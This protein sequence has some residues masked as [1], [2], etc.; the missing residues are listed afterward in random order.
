MKLLTAVMAPSRLERITTALDGAGLTVTTVATAQAS[1]MGESASQRYKGVEYRDQR[2]VRLEV[3]VDDVDLERA[4]AL[5]ATAD[6]QA[7]GAIVVWVSE[8]A[9]MSQ[10]RAR[11]FVSQS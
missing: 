9:E 8:V 6:D 5:V 3:L 1:G 7:S 4:V 11:E 10:V 2:C